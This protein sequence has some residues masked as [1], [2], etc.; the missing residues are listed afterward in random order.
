VKLIVGDAH[1][2]TRQD[3]VGFLLNRS[4]N[5]MTSHSAIRLPSWMCTENELPTSTALRLVGLEPKPLFTFPLF[6]CFR[7]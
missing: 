2:Q 4:S 5:R 1:A 3:E 7:H 6:R